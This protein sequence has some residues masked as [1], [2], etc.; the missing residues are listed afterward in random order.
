M[1]S[2]IKLCNP[3]FIVELKDL[4]KASDIYKLVRKNGIKKKYCYALIY[5][6]DL[7]TNEVIKIGESCPESKPTTD[8]AVGERLGR[9]I[10]WLNGWASYPKSNHGFDLKF[11]MDSEV[12]AGNLPSSA[13]DRCNISVGVWNLDTRSPDAYVGQDRDITLWVEGKL[14]E[15]YKITHS[16]LLPVL[17]YKDPTQNK[18]FR[19]GVVLKSHVDTIYNFS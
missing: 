13:L 2:D 1:F 17:N 4:K 12:K 15:D 11:N 10:A 6:K 14:A 7:L 18:I 5:R 16:N 9:Q 3:D 19:Q 8:K